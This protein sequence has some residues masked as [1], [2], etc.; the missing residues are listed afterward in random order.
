MKKT[1]HFLPLAMAAV[2]TLS[3]PSIAF[4]EG[5]GGTP[6]GFGNSSSVT[7]KQLPLLLLK[8]LRVKLIHQ[9]PQ[10]RMLF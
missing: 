3:A 1:K 7:Y 5:P 8:L 6:P 2:M 9:R 10:M 4:A